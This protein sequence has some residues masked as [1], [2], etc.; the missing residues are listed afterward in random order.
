M[1]KDSYTFEFLSLSEDAEEREIERG[2][3][4]RT[5]K[6]LLEVGSEEFFIDLPLYHLKLRCYVVVEL[7]G[8]RIQARVCLEDELRPD[9]APRRRAVDRDHP[10]PMGC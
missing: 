1:L 3:V 4:D 8:R 7:E 2:L 10:V 6:F 5:R 9:V